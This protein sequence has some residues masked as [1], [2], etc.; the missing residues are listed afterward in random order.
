MGP[1]DGPPWCRECEWNLDAFDEAASDR[2][3]T[4][5]GK[6]R[7][8][9]RQ[10]RSDRWF[11]ATDH[12]LG[13]RRDAAAYRRWSSAVPDRPHS[14]R[15]ALALLA[16][17][18]LFSAIALGALV[19]G[20]W[21][22]LTWN[23]W[24]VLLGLVLLVLA[25]EVRPRFG[26]LDDNPL[27]ELERDK[28]PTLF[29][30]ID[31][32]AQAVGCPTPDVIMVDH[33]FNASIGQYGLRRRSVLTIGLPLWAAVP[34]QGRIALLGHELGHRVNNDVNRNL[35][36]GAALRTPQV[37]AHLFD[38]ATL[39]RHNRQSGF[40]TEVVNLALTVL[41]APVHWIL[42][43]L[44]FAVSSVSAQQSQQ[45][46]YYADVIAA[47]VGG[48]SGLR[49]LSESLLVLPTIRTAMRRA[50]HAGG[51]PARWAAAAAGAR[52]AVIE[53][54]PLREQ[55]SMRYSASMFASHP[56]SGYRRRVVDQWPEA[57]PAVTLTDA[58]WAR[59]DAE[60]QPH[61]V[62]VRRDLLG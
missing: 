4:D 54:L 59:I 40:L 53:R 24:L 20:V 50:V 52:A 37:L 62:R 21:L 36:T 43:A 15:A 9:R 19:A 10:R 60:L 14:G 17:A 27:S 45:A 33:D 41:Y 58:E 25:F 23:F 26:H 46:E 61:Y 3:R 12:R 35:L 1:A 13:F 30:L 2:A 34:A 38:P 6:W 39:R 11:D 32:V 22:V 42:L 31:R 5:D 51:D 16:T 57:D 47:R 8:T 7:R 29:G 28:Q 55:I 49:S 56:P 44:T 18:L 48:S